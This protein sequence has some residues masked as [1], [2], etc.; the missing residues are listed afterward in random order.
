[1]PRDLIFYC[2]QNNAKVNREVKQQQQ[3]FIICQGIKI[4]NKLLGILFHSAEDRVQPKRKPRY[5][6]WKTLTHLQCVTIS[7]INK[8]KKEWLNI[9]QQHAGSSNGNRLFFLKTGLI[10]V[11]LC[12]TIK[13]F[14]TIKE[15][16]TMWEPR[17]IRESRKT[18]TV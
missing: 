17:G 1:M 6:L 10:I 11:L 3:K 5:L 9:R 2:D 13:K 16:L 18:V 12:G 15:R 14:C 4:K 8:L 7:K